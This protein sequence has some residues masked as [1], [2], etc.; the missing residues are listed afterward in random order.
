MFLLSISLR[1]VIIIVSQQWGY[2]GV[3]SF[4]GNGWILWD[5]TILRYR[6][7]GTVSASGPLQNNQWYQ[8]KVAAIVGTPKTDWSVPM[9]I[10]SW[11][12][13]LSMQYPVRQLHCWRIVSSV[14]RNRPYSYTWGGNIQNSS[15]LLG[16]LKGK[17]LMT[18]Y[19]QG[20]PH[21][22]HPLNHNSLHISSD[23][24]ASLLR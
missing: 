17:S 13:H 1:G 3:Q 16:S 20:S 19:S 22:N 18:R 6:M 15:I 14:S 21:H 9:I 2:Y 23:T 7:I 12:H 10:L 8:N 5:I 24:C 4:H 11:L